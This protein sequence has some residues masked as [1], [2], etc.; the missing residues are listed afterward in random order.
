VG[1]GK[2]IAFEAGAGA[3]LIVLLCAHVTCAAQ[4]RGGH[5]NG[6]EAHARQGDEPVTESFLNGTE[7]GRKILAYL[8]CTD[9]DCAGA[10]EEV[11]K[12][13]PRAVPTLLKLLRR[14]APPAVAPDLPKEKLSLLV[15]TRVMRALGRLREERAL[16]P[17]ASALRDESPLIRAGAAE[18]LGEVGGD[19][20]LEHL[21]PLLR[22]DDEL[23]RETTARALGALKLAAALP[24]LR[25]A[26]GAEKRPHVRRALEEAVGAIERR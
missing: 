14:D 10:L 11:V 23:V 22:D 1:R 18:A 4:D 26:L 6:D 5:T 3:L 19:A 17:L 9:F 25:E 15:R 24:A 8:R 16:G 13:G 12:L 20:A 21:T 2:H 7:D